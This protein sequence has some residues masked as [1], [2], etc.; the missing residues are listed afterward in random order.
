MSPVV[1]IE[2]SPFLKV[3]RREMEEKP[4]QG[5]QRQVLWQRKSYPGWPA[6]PASCWLGALYWVGQLD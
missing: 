4:R 6:V 2:R 5:A 1:S 3:S